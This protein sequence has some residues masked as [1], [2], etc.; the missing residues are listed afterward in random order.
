L[1]F[2]PPGKPDIINSIGFSSI[3]PPAKKSPCFL[4]RFCTLTNGKS[5]L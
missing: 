4:N 5:R 2:L 1:T 3:A